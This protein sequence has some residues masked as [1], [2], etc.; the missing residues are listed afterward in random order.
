MTTI[1]CLLVLVPWSSCFALDLGLGPRACFAF[2]Y[3]QH[4]PQWPVKAMSVFASADNPCADL[5][6]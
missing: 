3:Y 2:R 5:T 6:L 4:L 1:L